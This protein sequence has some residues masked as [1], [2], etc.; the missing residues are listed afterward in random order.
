FEVLNQEIPGRDANLTKKLAESKINASFQ[1]AEEREL[2]GELMPALV[3][4]QET[5][6]LDTTNKEVKFKI[7][8][9][10][11]DLAFEREEWDQAIVYFEKALQINPN[12]DP[13]IIIKI[14]Q[15]KA[16][17]YTSLKWISYAGFFIFCIF[18]GGYLFTRVRNPRKNKDEFRDSI[19]VKEKS[20]ITTSIKK[21]NLNSFFAFLV[22]FILIVLLTTLILI[23]DKAINFEQSV[24]LFSTI[25]IISLGII[26][27]VKRKT[28]NVSFSIKSKFL[29]FTLGKS[30][31]LNRNIDLISNKFFSKKVAIKNFDE[32]CFD[33]QKVVVGKNVFENCVIEIQPMKEKTNEICF[34]SNKN[35]LTINSLMIASDS[36][37]QLKNDYKKLFWEIL[38]KQKMTVNL[39]LYSNDLVDVE[40]DNCKISIDGEIINYSHRCCTLELKQKETIFLKQNRGKIIE[41][42]IE[43]LPFT[44]EDEVREICSLKD[45]HSISLFTNDDALSEVIDGK[46]K[47][48][49]TIKTLGRRETFKVE[50]N[51][52]EHLE[53]QANS[54]QLML[55]FYGDFKSLKIGRH[56][57]DA[58]NEEIPNLA[59]WMYNNQIFKII[60]AIL[61]WIGFLGAMKEAGLIEAI[62]KLAK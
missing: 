34:I 11:G 41:F 23:K 27:S 7:E 52:F 10:K 37:I 35:N 16:S 30:G 38:N 51:S 13:Q 56:N 19:D 29:R 8:K 57:L 46:I 36:D 22:L 58:Q 49:Q 17:K 39:D 43:M 40:T 6:K 48:D 28:T 44:R 54:K 59:L 53:I 15:A 25:F 61:A 45:V 1:F 42:D 24:L 32:I 9:L 4:Y 5:F 14:R 50:P 2:N 55:D 62:I 31:E 18:I 47:I 33:A 60:L 3:F 26:F 12:G 20:S 21:K